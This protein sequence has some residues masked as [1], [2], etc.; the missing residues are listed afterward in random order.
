MGGTE[1]TKLLKEFDPKIKI[2]ILTFHSSPDD[3]QAAFDAGA[4]A[5]CLKSI[6]LERLV[7]VMQSVF[8]RK[9]QSVR[10]AHSSGSITRNDDDEMPPMPPIL[11]REAPYLLTKREAQVLKLVARGKNN[12][13]I[14][15]DLVISTHTA[16][17]HVGNVVQKLFVSNRLQAAVKALKE[18]LC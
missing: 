1:A 18:G 11:T 6:G 14:A 4:D 8:Q 17:A 12:D 2:I 3:V 16:K 9:T 15:F 10:E 13:Q 5:Y 7:E